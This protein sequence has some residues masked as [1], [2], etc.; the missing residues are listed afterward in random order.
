MVRPY[1]KIGHECRRAAAVVDELMAA[2]LRG[3][4]GS[5]EPQHKQVA[6]RFVLRHVAALRY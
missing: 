2:A 4:E 3:R 5:I 1:S 6:V